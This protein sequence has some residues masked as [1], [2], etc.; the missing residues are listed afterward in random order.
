MDT[1]FICNYAPVYS[2]V[3]LRN[4]EVYHPT[5]SM[6]NILRPCP[7]FPLKIISG[8]IKKEAYRAI[9]IV[10]EALA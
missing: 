9:A 3:A 10:Y 2:N 5:T 8:L 7:D 1:Q 4:K 6:V